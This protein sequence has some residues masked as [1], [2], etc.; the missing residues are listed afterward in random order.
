MPNVR[1]RGLGHS[2]L[3]AAAVLASV[4]GFEVAGGDTPAASAAEPSVTVEPPLGTAAGAV[5][6]TGTG[7][8]SGQSVQVV[9]E[10]T[11]KQVCSATVATDGTIACAYNAGRAPGPPAPSAWARRRRDIG[12]SGSARSPRSPGAADGEPSRQAVVTQPTGVSTDAAGDVYVADAPANIVRRIGHASGVITTV[13]GVPQVATPSTPNAGYGGDGGKALGAELND[14]TGVAV[15]GRG[16]VYIADY[17]NDRVR[18]VVGS[19]HIIKTVA[20]DGTAGAAGDG[21]PATAAELNGPI[22]VAVD[23]QGNLYIG[24]AN[25]CVVREVAAATRT[26]STVVGDHICGF[27]GDGGPA[28]SAELSGQTYLAVDG[29]GD[30]Y[31]SDYHNNRVREVAAASHVITTVAGNGPDCGDTGNG[32]P[33]TSAALCLPLGIA[34]DAHRNLYIADSNN[35]VIRKVTPAGIISTV[36]GSGKYGDAGDG[37]PARAAKLSTTSGVAVD[38]ARDLFVSAFDFDTQGFNNVRE[39]SAASGTIST[40]VGGTEPKYGGDAYAATEA[41]TS[42]ACGLAVDAAGDV[43]L[44]DYFSARVRQVNAATGVITTIAGNGKTGFGGDGGPAGAAELNSPEGL[45]VDKAGDV[46]VADLGNNRVREISAATGDITTVAGDGK[47]GSSGDGGRATLAELNQPTAVAVDGAGDLFIYDSIN[48]AVREASASGNIS[49]VATGLPSGPGGVAVDDAGHLY[50][51]NNG[52]EKVTLSNDTVT[53][54]PGVD[55][56]DQSVALDGSGDVYLSGQTNYIV[57]K[58]VLSTETVS[59]IAGVGHNGYGGDGGPATA[60]TLYQ[61]MAVAADPN[62][63]VFV[64]TL[65][66]G[67]VREIV[68]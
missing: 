42:C 8:T 25:N 41:R 22:S 54:I 2:V 28:T 9:N 18:E 3:A 56:G 52:L 10:Q 21:G 24:D 46:F 23:H 12:P 43:Y 35:A 15:D 32:G 33:A 44:S 50:V 49:T 40:L 47:A 48:S 37:G 36:V 11:A 66:D 59:T 38:A 62:G 58:V 45:A 68:G 4:A 1:G 39:A 16:N 55:P 7:F 67:R 19:T 51:T 13:A 17:A 61:P 53:T 6:V 65:W 27:A 34:L 64:G 30:L 57:Q 60:A 29:A 14:P 31:L 5:T 26:I 20:G 63:D